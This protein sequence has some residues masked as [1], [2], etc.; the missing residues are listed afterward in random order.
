MSVS[1]YQKPIDNEDWS[2]YRI[3]IYQESRPNGG[4]FIEWRVFAGYSDSIIEGPS[5][6]NTLQSPP[7]YVHMDVDTPD[8]FETSNIR[9]I[10]ARTPNESDERRERFSSGTLAAPNAQRQFADAKAIFPFAYCGLVDQEWNKLP[11]NVEGSYRTITCYFQRNFDD[12]FN[13]DRCDREEVF[14]FYVGKGQ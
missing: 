14:C 10:I 9:F 8:N 3:E 7:F 13:D 6:E 1:E 11:K 12:I 4:S 5:R 2:Q